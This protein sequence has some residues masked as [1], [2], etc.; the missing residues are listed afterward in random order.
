ME[1]GTATSTHPSIV[2]VIM[3]SKNGGALENKVGELWTQLNW[4]NTYPVH[5]VFWVP[6]TAHRSWRQENRGL[7]SSTVQEVKTG[8][9][10]KKPCLKQSKGQED[11]TFIFM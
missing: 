9:G 8:L 10:Y 2:M 6:S 4:Q 11:K 1:N 5:T 3:K 7:R